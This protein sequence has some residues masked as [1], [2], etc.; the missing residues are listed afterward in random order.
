MIV[1][2]PKTTTILSSVLELIGFFLTSGVGVNL[3]DTLW[4]LRHPRGVPLVDPSTLGRKSYTHSPPSSIVAMRT[5][6][7]NAP[8][9]RNPD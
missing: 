5:S 7:K 3:G 8:L 4:G 6:Y 9:Q 2:T 1:H